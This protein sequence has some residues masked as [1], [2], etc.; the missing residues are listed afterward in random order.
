MA[1]PTV[2]AGVTSRMLEFAVERGADRGVLIHRS[3]IDPATLDDFDARIPLNKHITL[4]RAAKVECDDPA[5]ALHYGDAVNLAEVSVVGLIGYASAT[6][7][8]AFVQLS[9][10]SKVIVD[11]DLGLEARF[12]LEQDVRGLWIV[13]HRPLADELPELTEV[14][15][16]QMVNGTR[17]FGD[18]P[19]VI[20]VEISHEDPGYGQEYERVLG[21]P[22]TFGRVRNAM[23]IDPAWLLYPIAVQPRYVF[24]VLTRHADELLAKLHEPTMRQRVEQLVMPLLHTGAVGMERI[25]ADLG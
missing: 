10:Y 20:E 1:R 25:A 18:T 6:M 3:G 9:R 8:D 4:L 11:L 22:V 19:F 17:R 13:D 14:A 21:A 7:L 23:R 5:F 12:S 15:F 2:A 16:A 24:G